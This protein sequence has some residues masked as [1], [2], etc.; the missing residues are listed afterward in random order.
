[1]TSTCRFRSAPIYSNKERSKDSIYLCP[2]YTIQGGHLLL[3]LHTR[4]EISWGVAKLVPITELVIKW[5]EQLAAWDKVKALKFTP[6]KHYIT[7]M[8][9]LQEWMTTKMMIQL[10]QMKQKK[11][12]KKLLQIAEVAQE[13]ILL[14]LLRKAAALRVLDQI[15]AAM[16]KAE[17]SVNSLSGC[18]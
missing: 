13:G 8:I 4:E 6:I 9:I 15:Q 17:E 10:K 7:L 2:I 12:C 3:D 1:M 11:S 18:M 5:V 14:G 16:T